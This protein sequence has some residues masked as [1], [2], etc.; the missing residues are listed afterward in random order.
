MKNIIYYQKKNGN[1]PVRDFLRWL[2]RNNISLVTKIRAKIQLLKLE[3]LWERDVKYIGDKLFE[4]RIRDKNNISRVFY[5]THQ[6]DNIILLDA[7]IKK[8]NK[9]KN[10]DI[11]RCIDYKNDFQKRF[12]EW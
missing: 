5:F 7:I 3:L 6:W 9:L 2:T 10:T 8:Q 12:G 11:Q 4:L 1:I